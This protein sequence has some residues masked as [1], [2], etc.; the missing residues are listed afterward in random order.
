MYLSESILVPT[1]KKCGAS[2][3][4]AIGDDQAVFG[5]TLARCFVGNLNL[6][7]SSTSSDFSELRY[8]SKRLLETESTSKTFSS[9]KRIIGFFV[10]SKLTN[11]LH[12]WTLFSF[13]TWLMRCFLTLALDF[14]S[15][16]FFI[17]FRM[18]PL[19]IWSSWASWR[20]DTK[21]S[22]RIVALT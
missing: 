13:E 9:V 22:F 21:G 17:K 19:A 8:L 5:I 18:D 4:V 16:S 14:T 2:H 12:Y 7:L 20:C 3:L 15:K 10:L 1:G 6:M 11:F